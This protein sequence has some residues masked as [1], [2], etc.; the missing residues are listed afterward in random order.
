MH[1]ARY[2]R[3]RQTFRFRVHSHQLSTEGLSLRRSGRSRPRD[4]VRELRRTVRRHHCHVSIP[5]VWRY[6]CSRW[7]RVSLSACASGFVRRWSS[8]SKIS[9][10]SQYRLLIVPGNRLGAASAVG[11]DVTHA[12][13]RC[14]LSPSHHCTRGLHLPAPSL[15]GTARL[16]RKIG[17]VEPYPAWRDVRVLLDVFA[18]EQVM[19]QESGSVQA[20]IKPLSLAAFESNVAVARQPN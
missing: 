7:S 16:E 2:S 11:P 14:A 20:A 12:H 3:S 13:S 5:Y 10:E 19:V 9:L 17:L 15:R 18:H 1:D 8:S 6:L 4:H